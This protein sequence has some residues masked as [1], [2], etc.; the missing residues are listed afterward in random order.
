MKLAV[1]GEIGPAGGWFG[2]AQRLVEREGRDCVERGW[3]L[4]PVVFQRQA[5]RGLRG[6]IRGRG[7]AAVE[8]AERFGDPDLAA[9]A[10]HVQGMARIKQ[11][12][13]DEGLR[14]LDEAMVG[15]T[16]DAGVADRRGHRLLRRHRLAAR[17]RS[18]SAARRSGRT[19]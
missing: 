15:V 10:L 14:L 5:R 2:R 19:R 11:G 4:I 6:R 9:I 13:I 3:L 12:S 8:F 7:S 17:R 16:A 1:R 18:S